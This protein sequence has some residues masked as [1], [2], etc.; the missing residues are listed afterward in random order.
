MSKANINDVYI[1]E[2]EIYSDNRGFFLE[3]FNARVFNNLT[4][5]NYNFVQ[6]NHSYST[7]GVLRGLHYQLEHPQGKLVRV[8]SGSAFDV[9]ID[10]RVGSDYFGK[11][12]SITLS[13]NN[14]KT[15]WVPPGF[16]HGFLALEDHTQLLYKTTDYYHPHD[17]HTIHWEDPDLGIEWPDLMQDYIISAKDQKGKPFNESKYFNI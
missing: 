16:A 12:I 6:D 9:A 3:S 8:I 14:K 13:E 2:P 1:F 17:E 10:L 4:K 15:L 5:Q 11:H 7:K